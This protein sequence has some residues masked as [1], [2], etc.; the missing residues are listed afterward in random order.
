M[1]L[2]AGVKVT[3]L[4]PE[5]ALALQIAAGVYRRFG[6]ELVVTSLLDG[7]HSATSLHYVGHA[8]DLR[9]RDIPAA[10]HQDI[11]RELKAS[12]TTDYDVVLESDHIH[13]EYQPKRS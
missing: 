9:I 6:H 8:A 4:A 10:I 13:L 2:K 1:K 5:M 3:G 12:L 7:R 11:V